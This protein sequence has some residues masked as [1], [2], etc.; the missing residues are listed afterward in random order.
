[1]ESEVFEKQVVFVNKKVVE[2]IYNV[3]R[4][5]Y[6]IRPCKIPFYWFYIQDT[7]LPYK[8]LQFVP[9]GIYVDSPPPFFLAI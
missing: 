8:F 2:P 5:K 1:M 3:T 7:P 9:E 4:T 6:F